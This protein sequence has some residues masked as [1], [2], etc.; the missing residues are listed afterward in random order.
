[1][2]KGRYIPVLVTSFVRRNPDY[3]TMA[4]LEK[5]ARHRIP[6]YHVS[7]VKEVGSYWAPVKKLLAPPEVASMA[8]QVIEDMGADREYVFILALDTKHQ[9]IGLNMVS[10]GSLSASIVHPR[11]LFKALILLNANSFV[12]FHNHPSGDPNPSAEDVSITQRLKS[13]GELI[14]ILLLDHI[15]VGEGGYV[16]M[17]ESGFIG[18]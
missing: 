4:P 17:V 15:I 1:M 11:E 13:A 8:R 6:R 5:G 18:R 2:S 16:S 10:M 9:V 3:A 14:G 7:L 12:C